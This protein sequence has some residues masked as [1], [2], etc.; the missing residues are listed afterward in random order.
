M[1]LFAGKNQLFILINQFSDQFS[2]FL[3]L[4]VIEREH[5]S[6]MG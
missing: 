2:D 6:E 4:Q 5:W 1:N 3:F